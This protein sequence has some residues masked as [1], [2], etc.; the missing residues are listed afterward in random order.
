MSRGTTRRSAFGRRMRTVPN[1][2][3]S[4]T[5]ARPSGPPTN[6]PL[7][8]RSIEGDRARRRR[9]PDPLDDR[10]RVA[11][12]AQHVGQPRRLVR[13][14]DDP[15]V[16]GSP[17]LDGLDKST[18][19]TGRQDRLAPPERV[20][21]RERA[22]GH[23]DVLGRDRLPG[24]LEGPR[25]DEAALPVAGRQVGRRPVLRQLAGLDQLGAALVGLA[26]QEAGG[27]GDVA[28]L[29]E[30]E[31]GARTDVV[32]AGRRGEVGGPDLGGVADGH[33]P[34]RVRARG[35]LERFGVE[36][37]EVRG[38]A[39]RESRGG[40]AEAVAD[41]GGTTRAGAGTRTRA[42]GSRGRSCPSCAG[43]SGRTSATS[44]SRRRRTR[45]GSGAPS[46]AGRRPRSRRGAPT[47]PGPRPR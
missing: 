40:P 15:G 39:L 20:A 43:R 36:A 19:T 41:R 25:G 14:E 21:R 37:A 32:E 1:S 45:S 6:P 38:E 42:A 30:H 26:P 23:R 9:L 2:S 46:R 28:G 29:V 44:R 8:L 47:R 35:H 5:N 10:D 3:R 17:G 13:G 33:R 7:R 12:L 4:V 22:A 18:G 11:G 16:V 34:A 27:L 31:Q 24:E